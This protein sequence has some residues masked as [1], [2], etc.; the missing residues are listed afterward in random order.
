MATY[1]P[2]TLDKGVQSSGVLAEIDHRRV[3]SVLYVTTRSLTLTGVP[4]DLARS[5]RSDVEPHIYHLLS[6][7][8]SKGPYQLV[9]VPTVLVLATMG[10]PGDS[11]EELLIEVSEPVSETNGMDVD[12]VCV[13]VH[14]KRHQELRIALIGTTIREEDNIP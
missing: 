11:N 12:A 8:G 13:R 10:Q 5:E 1:T 2:A 9:D 3:L 6:P 7:D 14:S 4:L